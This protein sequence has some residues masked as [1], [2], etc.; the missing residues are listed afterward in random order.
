ME[1]RWSDGELKAWAEALSNDTPENLTERFAACRRLRI[2]EAVPVAVLYA[3]LPTEEDGRTQWHVLEA[4]KYL[5][6]FDDATILRA[7][8]ER[9]K[10]QPESAPAFARRLLGLIR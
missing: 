5:S 10:R 3:A 1:E 9:M 4:R 8:D 7:V 2:Q 6:D